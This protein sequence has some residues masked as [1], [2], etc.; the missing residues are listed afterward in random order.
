MTPFNRL[1]RAM[2]LLGCLLLSMASAKTHVELILDASG[3]MYNKLP[4]GQSRIQAA[5][6]VL[7]SFIGSLPED[8]ELNVG[9][10]IY[11]AKTVAGT[12]GS[13][14]DSELVLPIEGLN[15]AALQETV[16][17]TTPK[18]ATPIAFSL[19]KA[20]EDFSNDASKKLIVL[21][22]D[23]QESCKG[24]LKAALDAFKKRGIDVDLRIVG[25]DL[26][27][28]AVQS[29][30][31]LGTIE[32][33]RSAGTLAAALGRA[34]ETV[35][36]AEDRTYPITVQLTRDGQP[37]PGGSRVYLTNT[38]ERTRK[39][40]LRPTAQAGE[41]TATVP[42]GSY[43][44]TVES[45][46]QER[47]VYS[48]I[49]VNVGAENRFSFETRKLD[50]KV[51]LT[52]GS[53]TPLAGS[54]LEVQ[55]SGA[56]ELGEGWI[57]LTTEDAAEGS[58]LNWEAAEGASGK[59][60]F[61]VPEVIQAYVL[62][63]HFPNPDGSLQ[64][65]GQSAPFTPRK[66]EVSVKVPAEVLSGQDFA[67]E[68]KG[69]ANE[70]DYL[71]V[72]PENAP[73]GTYT[74]Y[75]YAGPNAE[76]QLPAPVEAGTFE[77]RYISGQGNTLA[78]APLKVKLDAYSV[79]GPSEAVAGSLITVGWKGG[80]AN[81]DY[82]TVVRAGA[83]DRAYTDYAYTKDKPDQKAE[84]KTPVQ[85]GEYEIRYNT[86]RGKVYARAKLTL[87]AGTYGLTFPAEVIA[88]SNLTLQWT[89][90]NNPG[91]YITIVP[92]S[93]QD[94]QYMKYAYTS[95]G[96]PLEVGTPGTPGD[97]EVRYMSE[98]G[99]VVLYR[100]ALKLTAAK[101][102]LKF[103]ASMQAGGHVSIQWT[104]PNNP[105]DYI[106]IVPKNAQDGQYGVYA[107]TDQNPIVLQLPRTAGEYEIRYMNDQQGN[108][109][110]FRKPFTLT[111]PRATLKAPASV[112]AG[113]MFT[114]NWTGPAGD[115]DAIFIV[116]K[117]APQDARDFGFDLT[118]GGQVEASAPET[119]GT[120]EIRYLTG[121]G[122]VLVSI[123]LIVK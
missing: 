88:G 12:Q 68:W 107:Y 70:G 5:K 15:R 115:G 78:S 56:P 73:E 61:T 72:V 54:K 6:D 3:S 120:Y 40:D 55:Y 98:S 34:V 14:E 67:V 47:R 4:D 101:Y 96:N 94:G 75:F 41:Y 18:G 102:D 9:L 51:K 112:N 58:Y 60:Q 31:G 118:E 83:D 123:P 10:R 65:L 13:C 114:L 122:Q 36:R 23:G 80:G 57:A 46:G 45:P 69:P 89:G 91:D 82:V 76:N 25:I 111:A 74:Q 79:S 26:D 100:K 62:R 99:N 71:T 84:L 37:D 39:Y 108:I 64:T 38:V 32:N 30:Q 52:L 106:T 48:G 85:P 53:T 63:Y 19:L 97:A 86:E 117:G 92:K 66:A 20:A 29:F 81:G 24:D 121:E 7:N 35:A 116:K 33:A 50:N 104:G 42:A 113:A 22:T 8:P 59:V 43:E 11:G 2:A 17:K 87:K 93:A 28:R 103:P 16:R 44:A 95:S 105:G 49:N 1:H 110:V 119:P 90:P 27:E 21:V 109:V 77:V